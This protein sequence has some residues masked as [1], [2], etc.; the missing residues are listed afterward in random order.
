MKAAIVFICLIVAGFY[1]YKNFSGAIPV[2]DSDKRAYAGIREQDMPSPF[3]PAPFLM[4][5]V[6]TVIVVCTR[7]APEC[8]DYKTNYVPQL[9]A[10]RPDLSV[11]F[12][13]LSSG[14]LQTGKTLNH[15]GI[16]VKTVPAIRVYSPR[17]FLI[18]ADTPTLPA[19]KDLL[20]KAIEEATKKRR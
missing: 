2:S 4:K 13:Y 1:A 17:G 3:D 15:Y 10:H 8:K 5:G 20:K 18:E 6:S 19:G 9:L 16:D 7:E 14:I 11:Q 12:V